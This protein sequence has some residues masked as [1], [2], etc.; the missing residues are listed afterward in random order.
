MAEQ[1]N[2]KLAVIVHADVVGSTDLVQRDELLAHQRMQDCFER[3]STLIAA[4]GGNTREI[5]GDALVAEFARAS[6]AVSAAVA[7]QVQNKREVTAPDDEIAPSLRIGISLGE[8]IVAERTVTGAGVVLAQRLEQL[9]KPGGVIVQGSVSETVP[10]RL[11]FHFESLGEH[12]LK[13]FEHPVRCFSVELPADATLP[14]PEA[15]PAKTHQGTPATARIDAPVLPDKPSI[16]VLPFTNMS[17]DPEQEY[18]SDGVSEDIITELSKV[19]ALFVIARNSAF[20]YKSRAVDVRDACREL[21]V[22]FALEGS[23]RK[24]GNRVRITAQL[25]DGTTGGHLWAER[26][27]RE[28][29]DIFEV[30]DDVTREIVSALAPKLSNRS[31]TAREPTQDFEAYDSLLRG[32]EQWWRLSRQSN[33]EAR[34]MFEHAVGLDAKFARAWAWL[35]AT[36]LLDAVNQ[37]SDSVEDSVLRHKEFAT[38]AVALDGEDAFARLQMG[39]AYVTSREH[40]LAIAEGEKSIALDPNFAHARYDLA[41]F[42]HCAGR[43]EEA[44]A[45]LDEAVRLDPHFSDVYLH[46]RALCFFQLKEYEKAVDALNRR[47]TRRPDSDISNVLL[48]ACYGH[49]GRASEGQ[50]AWRTALKYNPDYSLEHKRRVLPYKDAADFEHLKSGLKNAGAFASSPERGDPSPDTRAG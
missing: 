44:L 32:R 12:E 8:V 39:M 34:Q 21:G 47:L 37:W 1:P 29:T 33:I 19:S 42:L 49:L 30:Q 22:R 3:F 10:T 17:S 5:R 43:S 13:G 41:W 15:A 27:D 2:R 36:H 31:A 6:D 38:R 35:A 11:P 48:A 7:F 50:N 46:L 45:M 25:L 24:A 9:A 20:T 18:F 26:Y 16:V 28:L 14:P 4:Y 40:D 23:I